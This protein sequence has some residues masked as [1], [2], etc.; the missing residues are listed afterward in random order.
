MKDMY[1]KEAPFFTPV[2]KDFA[3]VGAG[4]INFREILAVKD[5]AGMKYMIVEEDDSRD[6]TIFED[7]K[8]SI[9]NL[10]TG[11]LV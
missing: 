8:T 6:G 9:T 11:I 1:T 5:I 2:K 10:T 4:I 7:V 3:P